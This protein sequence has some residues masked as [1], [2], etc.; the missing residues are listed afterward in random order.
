MMN[1]DA[2]PTDKADAPRT[3]AYE[4]PLIEE[5]ITPEELEREVH[6]AGD[7]SQPTG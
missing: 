4:A 1:E 3:A 2:T 5:T 6:Y 7:G